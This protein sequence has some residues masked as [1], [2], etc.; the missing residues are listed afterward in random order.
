MILFH[1]ILSELVDIRNVQSQYVSRHR[2]SPLIAL[3]EEDPTKG[4]LPI[5]EFCSPEPISP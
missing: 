4:K 3:T 2:H 1:S 5:E